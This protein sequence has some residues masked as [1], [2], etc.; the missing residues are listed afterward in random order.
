MKRASSDARREFD[1]G[2]TVAVIS[3]FGDLGLFGPKPRDPIEMTVAFLGLTGPMGGLPRPYTEL[4]MQRIR[5]GD[6]ALRS[7][8]TSSTSA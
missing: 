8:S 4:V 7:F 5:K 2:P 1:F 6:M 3:A